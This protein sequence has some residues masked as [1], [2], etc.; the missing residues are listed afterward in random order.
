MRV[1][2]AAQAEKWSLPA[3][4]LDGKRRFAADGIEWDESLVYW[5]SETGST[6]ERG[7]F[8]EF[9]AEATSGG[10][11]RA[12]VHAID[13]FGRNLRNNIDL[14]D[15]LESRGVQ[16]V[17]LTEGVDFSSDEGDMLFKQLST[18]SEYFLKKLAREVRKG[19]GARVRGGFSNAT[20]PP[21]GY[22]AVLGPDGRPLALYEP[23][24]K[25]RE[26]VRLAYRWYATGRMSYQDIADRL[27]AMGFRGP[28]RRGNNGTISHQS[29]RQWL[30][31]PFYCGLVVH[32]EWRL[33]WDVRRGKRVRRVVRQETAPGKHEPLVTREEWEAVQAVAPTRY[34]AGRAAHSRW[35]VYILGG[36]HAVC[37]GCGRPLAAGMSGG[38]RYYRC[39]SAVQGILCPSSQ[40][41]IKA[42]VLE[43]TLDPLF[44]RL[45]LPEDAV[46]RGLASLAGQAVDVQR[47]R[48]A[49]A[50]QR[51]RL[52]RV[53][54]QPGSVVTDDEFQRQ[55]AALV[56][57]MEAVGRAR[58]LDE[59]KAA[60]ARAAELYRDVAQVWRLSSLSSRRDLFQALF[61][62]A[63]VDTDAA[64]VTR[65]R[66]APYT[67]ALF[68]VPDVDGW[69]AL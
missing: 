31:N 56:A 5:D 59:L 8:Q 7:G 46:R 62:T 15:M 17:S 34:N 61:V 44:A 25:T 65:V 11:S 58:D 60:L 69:W 21:Y 37:S 29:V 53:Y 6:S 49:L 43:A 26:A 52:A 12:Y 45:V 63:E 4:L 38:R 35:G 51:R 48:D 39:T 9:L 13:R 33:V 32:R 47:Q 41:R 24:P 30:T 36:K 68:G 2:S 27:N 57:Q 64:R 54:Q 10:Y 66:P 42:D 55:D 19:K 3:Q 22:R 20:L 18:Y 50:E 28:G 14:K 67:L 1:S 23:D 16:L 40:L